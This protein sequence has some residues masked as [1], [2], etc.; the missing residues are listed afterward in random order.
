MR[1]GLESLATLPWLVRLRWIALLGQVVA[2]VLYHRELETPLQWPIVAPVFGF[3]ALSN[4]ALMTWLRRDP[5]PE[6][7]HVAMIAVLTVDT[8]LLTALLAASGGPAN[9]FTIFYIVHIV[10]AAVVLETRAT[11]WVTMLS[12]LCF[13]ALFVLPADPHAMHHQ[14]PGMI[15]GHL[16]GM[17]IAFAIAASVIAY[18]VRKIS[19]TLAMQREQIA[20]LHARDASRARLASLAALA[21]GAAHELG[22]PLGTI[23]VAVRELELALERGDPIDEPVADARL[24]AAEVE[25]CRLIL[26]GMAAQTQADD[27]MPITTR[28]E[29]LFAALR[30]RFDAERA[31]RITCHAQPD[32]R[33]FRIPLHG[34]VRSLAA[35][36]KNAFDASDDEAG[37][38]EVELEID[39]RDP[40][41]VHTIVRDRGIGMAADIRARAGE[42]FFTT[43]DPGSGMGLGLF[44]VRSFVESI[45]GRL[46]LRAIA[47]RGTEAVLTIPCTLNAELTAQVR[48]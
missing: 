36:V 31:L 45:G 39:T 15:E 22:T 27:T 37:T 38:V 10:L 47:P 32:T 40:S 28:P 2:L 21:A 48:A 7:T 20:I 18:F 41:E 34:V 14:H 35:L 3:T 13:A 5:P 9:P 16:R 4:V 17:W 25:R 26:G 23:A 46:E 33:S 43:K 42:P 11:V 12:A 8:V 29:Q 6:R 24:I 19:L 44:L 1:A 30:A